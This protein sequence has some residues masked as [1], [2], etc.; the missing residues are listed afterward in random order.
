MLVSNSE[1]LAWE[2]E[3]WAIL[4]V[5]IAKDVVRLV[6]QRGCRLSVM[7]SGSSIYCED[8]SLVL[9]LCGCCGTAF[10]HALT[11]TTDQLAAKA[12][13]SQHPEPHN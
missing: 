11:K 4:M 9:R 12:I 7:G 5:A 1:G 8:E 13:L 6:V 2:G 3:L 10:Y